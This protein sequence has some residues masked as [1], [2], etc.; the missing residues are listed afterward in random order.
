MPSSRI[1]RRPRGGRGSAG[2][3]PADAALWRPLA[4][5]SNNAWLICERPALWRQTN[6][7]RGHHS[8]PLVAEQRADVLEGAVRDRPVGERSALLALDDAGVEQLL[9]VVADRRLLE[10]E[11]LLE[12]ADADRLAAGWTQPV[13]DLHAVAVGERLEHPLELARLVVGHARLGE[14]RAA[15]HERQRGRHARDHIEKT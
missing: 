5:R 2:V 15:L 14:R 10:L 12:V 3:V 1:T 4:A 9:E 6:R 8:Q 13:E 11:Q 7:T